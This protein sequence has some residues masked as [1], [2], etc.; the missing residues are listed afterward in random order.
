MKTVN[1]NKWMGRK[2]KIHKYLSPMYLIESG[3]LFI[4]LYRL[5]ELEHTLYKRSL[6]EKNTEAFIVKDLKPGKGYDPTRTKSF[7]HRVRNA[8]Y[9]R[10]TGLYQDMLIE[11]LLEGHIIVLPGGL[12]QLQIMDVS[13]IHKKYN[14]K[15]RGQQP[16]IMHTQASLKVWTKMGTKGYQNIE[17]YNK[18]KFTALVTDYIIETGIRYPKLEQ[19]TKANGQHTI[20]KSQS[21]TYVT[22]EELQRQAI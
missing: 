6:I 22:G 15:T 19:K 10:L 12:G 14:I 4:P 16:R 8:I 18:M 17:F 13:A 5:V 1:P 9:K 7:Y 3:R 2:A 21:N 11:K 20:Y